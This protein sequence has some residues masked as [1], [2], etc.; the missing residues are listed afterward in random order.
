VF[1]KRKRS[2]DSIKKDYFWRQGSADK[3]IALFLTAVSVAVENKAI[4]G[5]PLGL[6]KIMHY[7]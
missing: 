4:F 3:N 7:F 6:S 1:D 2:W 5:G